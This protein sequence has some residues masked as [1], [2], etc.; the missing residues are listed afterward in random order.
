MAVQ[1][2]SIQ[3]QE[4]SVPDKIGFWSVVSIVLGSQIGSGIF[5]LPAGLAVFGGIGLLSWLASGAGAIVLALVFAEL[6]KQIPKTGGPHA[7]V[8]AAFGPKMGFLTAWSYWVISWVSSSAVVIAAV[9]YVGSIFGG[10][11]P[12]VN[13]TA[14]IILLLL[15]MGLNLLGVRTSGHAEFIFTLLKVVPLVLLPLACIPFLNIAHFTPLNLSTLSVPHAL[16]AAALLTFW[17]FIGIET[18]TTPAGSV[19]QP[20]KTIPRAIVLGTI[21]VAL[22]YFLSSA[23]I[24]GVVP[25]AELKGTQAPFADATRYIFGGSYHVVIAIV[26]AIVCIGTLNA[27]ILAS[28]QIALGAAEDR[29]FPELFRRQNRHGAPVWGV[30]LS[31]LGVIPLLW[32]TLHQNLVEQLTKIIDG[33]VTTFLFIYGLCVISY[34]RL[35]YQHS[36][37]LRKKICGWLALGF[38]AWALGGSSLAMVGLACGVFLSAVP[39]YL[40]LQRSS[41]C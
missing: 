27:W 4:K 19:E 37:P 9:G 6:C 36:A 24:M 28:G 1:E 23:A 8:Q 30:T 20:E 25:P 29:L 31:S 18:A 7:F 14:E 13:L 41:Q 2:K 3:D 17:G 39:V 5:M 22:I 32:L 10:F 26:A 12:L 11:P 21:A 34:L 35:S 40:W 16:N 33:S 38:C 15:L